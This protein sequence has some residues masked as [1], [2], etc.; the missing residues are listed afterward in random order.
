M[1]AGEGSLAEA[2]W[3]AEARDG[4]ADAGCSDNVAYSAPVK[5][6]MSRRIGCIADP[7]G[8][9]GTTELLDAFFD[10]A[11]ADA[12]S[13][14]G[15]A[16]L[17]GWRR[18]VVTGTTGF[19]CVSTSV[20]C[21]RSRTAASPLEAEGSA[22][23]MAELLELGSTG[24]NCWADAAVPLLDEGGVER[25]EPTGGSFDGVGCLETGGLG[26][27]DVRPDLS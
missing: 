4:A 1:V 14:A 2:A 26:P 17:L 22:A 11:A 5:S 16:M 23:T 25:T 19:V 9:R 24:T 20:R 8:V 21:S 27:R 3:D 13:A 15:A 6:R 10:G 12:S 7:A 18:S